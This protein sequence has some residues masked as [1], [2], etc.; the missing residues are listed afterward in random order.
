MPD[1]GTV[2]DDAWQRFVGNKIT[3]GRQA[4]MVLVML[5]TDLNVYWTSTDETSKGTL[6]AVAVGLSLM[7]ITPYSTSTP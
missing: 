3:A 2:G 7:N 4:D 1:G 6:P 5:D